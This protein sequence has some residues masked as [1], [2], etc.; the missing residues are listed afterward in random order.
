MGEWCTRRGGFPKHF[1]AKG[2]GLKALSSLNKTG[3]AY[4]RWGG[5]HER[6]RYLCE[7]KCAIFRLGQALKMT[8]KITQQLF[9]LINRT[10][11]QKS[12]LKSYM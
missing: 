2:E 1:F 3:V 4:M 11:A 9:V 10:I 7:N 8:A 6:V 5:F 12:V